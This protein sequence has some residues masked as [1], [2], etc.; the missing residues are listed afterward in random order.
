MKGEIRPDKN[1]QLAI[2]NL[3]CLSPQTPC[4]AILPQPHI[5]RLFLFMGCCAFF[6][7]E[8]GRGAGTSNLDLTQKPHSKSVDPRNCQPQKPKPEAGPPKAPGTH[9]VYI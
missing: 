5:D 2:L 6:L 7:E 3:L 8:A 1:W 9:I 4:F